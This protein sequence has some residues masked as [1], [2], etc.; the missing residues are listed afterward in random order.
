MP[1]QHQDAVLHSTVR[2]HRETRDR[3]VRLDTEAKHIAEAILRL[4]H[5]LYHDPARVFFE[6]QAHTPHFL[7]D[8]LF[9]DSDCPNVEQI[10]RLTRELREVGEKRI[11]LAEQLERLRCDAS[12][13]GPRALPALKR[14]LQSPIPSDASRTTSK[15][16]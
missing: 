4:G 15:S 6:G 11:R 12:H 10:K 14:D 8:A 9:G 13:C 5:A 3:E 2:E 1:R 7:S 16:S